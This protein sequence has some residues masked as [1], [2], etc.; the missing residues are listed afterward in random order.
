M[1]C[2]LLAWPR[3]LHKNQNPFWTSYAPFPF[4]LCC[5]EKGATNFPFQHRPFFFPPSHRLLLDT[6]AQKK[7]LLVPVGRSIVGKKKRHRSQSAK[8]HHKSFVVR[9]HGSNLT[10]KLVM[11]FWPF[12]C[13]TQAPNQHQGT[14]HFPNFMLRQ[15]AGTENQISGWCAILYTAADQTHGRPLKPLVSCVPW[16]DMCMQFPPHPLHVFSAIHP[17]LLLSLLHTGGK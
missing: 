13:A 2:Q 16:Q 1:P 6:H 12:I 11:L 15:D 7:S 17:S 4:S 10:P 8:S 3:Q 14:P 5:Q 9:S